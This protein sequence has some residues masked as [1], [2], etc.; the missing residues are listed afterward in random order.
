MV[1]KV[2]VVKPTLSAANG[3]THTHIRG[4]YH[5][6]R[7]KT[8]KSRAKRLS[9]EVYNERRRLKRAA[10][11]ARSAGNFETANELM[12]RAREL[13]GSHS[14]YSAD[15]QKQVAEARA[16]RENLAHQRQREQANAARVARENVMFAQKWRWAYDQVITKDTALL[17]AANMGRIP[18][19]GGA[20]YE[21]A[22]LH[23]QM[24]MA[25]VFRNAFATYWSSRVQGGKNDL[26]WVNEISRGYANGTMSVYE[27]WRRFWNRDDPEMQ[28]LK[29]IINQRSSDF[30]RGVKN[31]DH[32]AKFW[33]EWYHDQINE[34]GT[35][36]AE[37]MRFWLFPG[38]AGAGAD[39]DD[40]TYIRKRDEDGFFI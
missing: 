6:A 10:D 20:A 40:F 32:D 23:R 18:G 38:S 3:Y 35:A 4:N 22:N 30:A 28:R 14:G 39:V 17:R 8:P 9:D 2:K 11:K 16:Y 36:V 13:Y 33:A 1:R 29:E 26:A 24:M 5:K 19:V 21:K 15:I 25:R 37:D 34:R 12:D 27:I 31:P 7:V